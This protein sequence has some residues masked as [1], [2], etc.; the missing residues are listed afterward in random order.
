MNRREQ[1]LLVDIDTE[2]KDIST[3][4]HELARRRQILQH[5]ATRLRTGESA[6]VVEALLQKDGIER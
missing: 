5:A 4:Q 6:A 1:E 3:Q 2:M